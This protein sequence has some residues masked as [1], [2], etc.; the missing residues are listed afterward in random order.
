VLDDPVVCEHD[1]QGAIGN[2]LSVVENYSPP[3]EPAYGMHHMLDDD[4]RYSGVA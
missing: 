3:G 4:D 1:L 2:L